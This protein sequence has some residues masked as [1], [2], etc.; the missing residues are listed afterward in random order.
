M[1]HAVRFNIVFDGQLAQGKTEAQVR[2]NL[3]QHFKCEP[4]QI[5]QL[6]V[7]HPVIVKQDLDEVEANVY[8]QCFLELGA[9]V[10]KLA[11]TPATRQSPQ[12]Q[13]SPQT[14]LGDAP[15]P[16]RE[17]KLPASPP[18][19]WAERRL[20]V[21]FA[22]FVLLL[23]GWNGL[24]SL[25]VPGVHDLTFF[26]LLSII[27]TPGSKA[28]GSSGIYGL[29]AWT[30]LLAILLPALWRH[31]AAHLGAILPLPLYV[32]VF[33][34][35]LFE[36]TKLPTMTGYAQAWSIFSSTL[37]GGF[38]ASLLLCIG[39]SWVAVRDFRAAAR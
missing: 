37:G 21:R 31:R 13:Q 9:I 15:P 14:P 7:G 20:L 32:A 34:G 30:A 19:Q 5:D 2:A 16:E 10:R 24:N 12:T 36:L 39:C 27:N 1:N 25:T 28:G 11:A 29:L 23:I 4:A 38:Y 33:I 8:L 35:L 6:F 26:E 18:P 17:E 22:L 3:A